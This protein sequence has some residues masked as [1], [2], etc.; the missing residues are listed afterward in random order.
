MAGSSLGHQLVKK[1]PAQSS[2]HC[3]VLTERMVEWMDINP[4]ATRNRPRSGRQAEGQAE[5]WVGS[6]Q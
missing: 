1:G 5:S 3:L 4:L 2:A 6:I